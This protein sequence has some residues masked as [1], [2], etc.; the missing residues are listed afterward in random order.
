MKRVLIIVFTALAFSLLINSSSVRILYAQQ[1]TPEPTP[2]LGP[3]GILPQ[4]PS[5]LRK[6]RPPEV[7][8]PLGPTGE[9]PQLPS[10]SKDR[11]TELPPRVDSEREGGETKEL[12]ELE[13]SHK[14]LIRLLIEK[15]VFTQKEFSD[16]MDLVDREMKKKEMEE[17]S[18]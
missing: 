15:G 5:D 13:L 6:Q 8:P 3:K 14:A 9:V 12:K 7:K 2:P 11:A 18:K 10:G 1:R 17:K 4:L 16:K